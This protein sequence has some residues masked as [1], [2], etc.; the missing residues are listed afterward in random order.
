MYPSE[1]TEHL[2]LL[3]CVEM[4]NLMLNNYFR[5]CFL[6]MMVTL[7]TQNLKKRYSYETDSQFFSSVLDAHTERRESENF[8]KLR[9]NERSVLEDKEI[10]GQRSN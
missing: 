5:G 9:E 10:L 3:S 4:T 1:T 7:R 2:S 8:V 6:E